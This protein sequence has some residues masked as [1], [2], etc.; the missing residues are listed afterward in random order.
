M[1]YLLILSEMANEQPFCII[2]VRMLVSGYSIKLS[3]GCWVSPIFKLFSKQSSLTV[4]STDEFFHVFRLKLLVYFL[5]IRTESSFF[6][7]FSPVI[8]VQGCHHFATKYYFIW[9]KLVTFSLCT[10]QAHF[11]RRQ[12]LHPG[13]SS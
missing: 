12:D 10:S 7:P 6:K 9:C 8:C 5:Y 3:T 1:W 13:F 11:Y 2:C 4:F